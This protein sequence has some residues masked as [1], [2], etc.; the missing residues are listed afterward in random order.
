VVGTRPDQLQE[1]ANLVAVNDPDWARRGQ[2]VIDS[3]LR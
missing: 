3:Q 2:E 1:N